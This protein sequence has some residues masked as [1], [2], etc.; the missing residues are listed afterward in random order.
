[1]YMRGSIFLN[2]VNFCSYRNIKNNSQID[3]H[4][5]PQTTIFYDHA[6][7]LCRFEMQHLKQLDKHNR[8]AQIDISAADFAADEWSMNPEDLNR[9]LHVL[10]PA[11]EWLVGLPAARHI[12][13]QL[14]MGWLIAMTEL[15]VIAPLL[16]T[17]YLRFARNRMQI[18]R[19]FGLIPGHSDCMDGTCELK[20][21][22]NRSEA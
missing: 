15:P 16:D 20:A 19:W 4:G 13:R 7:P 1:M 11:G 10:T 9:A 21:A 17:A 12:Y 6:C 22:G 2:L 3:V 14:G 5:M 8:L 18:S